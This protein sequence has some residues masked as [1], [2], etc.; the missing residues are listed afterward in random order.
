MRAKELSMMYLY[1]DCAGNWPVTGEF[2]SKRPVTR[3]FDV[4]FDAV[5]EQTVEET[6]ETLVIWDAVALIMTSM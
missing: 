1:L 2:P 4:F 5:P 6:I 3:S